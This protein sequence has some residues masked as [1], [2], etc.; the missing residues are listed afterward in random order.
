MP[1]RRP[2]RIRPRPP[3]R[4]S[5]RWIRPPAPRAKRI[6]TRPATTATG[7]AYAA[8]RSETPAVACA[9]ATPAGTASAATRPK[10]AASDARWLLLRVRAA[11]GGGRH[12]AADDAGHGDQGEDVRQCLEEHGRGVGVDREAERERR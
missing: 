7:I 1:S 5:V 3:A 10:S 11:N 9:T 6:A 2:R 12:R 4:S 8:S